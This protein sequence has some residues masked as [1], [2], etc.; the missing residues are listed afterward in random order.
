MAI[1]NK[2]E[3]VSGELDPERCQGSTTRGPCP[4]KGNIDGRF[5]PMHAGG[6]NI[7]HLNRKAVRNFRLTQWQSRVDEFADSTEVK[8]LRE[9][10]G[11]M[12]LLLENTMNR[13]KT[14]D[15]LYA[16]TG[17]ISDIVGRLEKL[18]GTCHRLELANESLMDRSTVLRIASAM[19]E[20]IGE[21]ITDEKVLDIIGDRIV[22][23]ILSK[24]TQLQKIDQKVLP[25]QAS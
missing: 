13:Y 17:K 16:G 7:H 22:T 19:V 6:S 5:C 21:F 12:R 4:Y 10:V 3:R 1:D 18:V 24:H 11:I 14:P 25:A 15:E 8:S 2:F 23:A 20:I 9:E